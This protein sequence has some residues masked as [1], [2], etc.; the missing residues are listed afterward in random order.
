MCPFM[1]FG[2]YYCADQV[3]GDTDKIENLFVLCC[4]LRHSRNRKDWSR[5]VWATRNADSTSLVGCLIRLFSSSMSFQLIN[6]KF[7]MVAERDRKVAALSPI[8]KKRKSCRFFE[9]QS[10]AHRRGVFRDF[11][12]I[13]PIQ[14]WDGHW[15]CGYGIF[16][17]CRLCAYLH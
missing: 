8:H 13:Q 4:C 12:P 15:P 3:Q 16:G 1:D 10:S 11:H 17:S 5:W 7:M 2:Y 14:V 9:P 6:I